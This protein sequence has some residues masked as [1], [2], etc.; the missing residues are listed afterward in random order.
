MRCRERKSE[1]HF[2][3]FYY[4]YRQKVFEDLFCYTKLPTINEI[5]QN[6]VLF[7]LWDELEM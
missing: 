7:Q 5:K 6:F 4:N 2:S 3:V 1:V